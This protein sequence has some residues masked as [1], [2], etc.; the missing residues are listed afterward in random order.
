MSIKPG[1]NHTDPFNLLITNNMLHIQKV[2]FMDA[3]MNTVICVNAHG[4]ATVS[5]Y[6]SFSE[7]IVDV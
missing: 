6:K 1:K 3:A 4:I 2:R 7:D 5:F